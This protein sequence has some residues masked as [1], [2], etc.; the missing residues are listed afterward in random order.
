MKRLLPTLVTLLATLGSAGAARANEVLHWNRVATEESAAVNTDPLTESRMFAILQLA[1]HDAVNAAGP[2]YETYL[3]PR[4]VEKGTS[5]EA[6]AA[7]A[8]HEVLVRMLPSRKK[9][10]DLQ[11]EKSLH[12]LS[13]GR[14]T[15]SGVA[16]GRAVAG[17]VLEARKADGADRKVNPPPGTKPGEYRPTP[18]DL[19]PAFMG[20][21]GGIEPFALTSPA[22]FR[23]GPPPAVDGER[24]HLDL[25][26]VR[27]VGASKGSTRSDEQSEIARFW[28]E[29][30]TQGWNRITRSIAMERGLDLHDSARLFALVNMAMADGFIAG[31]EAKYYYNYWRPVTAIREAG[32]RD[33]LSYLMTPPIPDYPSNH[34][35]LGAAAATVLARFCGTDYVSFRMTSGAPYAGIT[36]RFWSFSEAARENGASRVFA[37][38]HFPTAVAE[39]YAQGELVGAWVFDHALRPQSQT[40]AVSA[41]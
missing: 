37:G 34:T 22:Q 21:W 11:L 41:R 31:F 16:V 33:W 24:A 25:E 15:D 7:A 32:E 20:Q 29:H 12:Q 35:V 38:I 28:Y 5:A 30:S 27:S 8:A 26:I 9:N 4:A 14:A 23:P 36:R 19:T 40:T 3:G 13:K 39:G 18:P 17:A 6:A 2:R 10:F 1:M